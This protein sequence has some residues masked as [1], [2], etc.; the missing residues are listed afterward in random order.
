[1]ERQSKLA[2]LRLVTK[3]CPVSN[4]SY[5]RT[6]SPA[7]RSR[8]EE[9]GWLASDHTLSLG[10]ADDNSS[11][12][13]PDHDAHYHVTGAELWDSFWQAGHSKEAII[14]WK[15]RQG[16]LREQ[17]ASNYH[18]A[19]CSSR[20]PEQQQANDKR[21]YDP[22]L[23]H[24]CVGKSYHL[25]QEEPTSQH[26]QTYKH[27]L[28]STTPTTKHAPSPS[29]SLFPRAVADCARHAIPP[30]AASLLRPATPSAPLPEEIPM[31]PLR[32]HASRPSFASTCT[33]ASATSTVAASVAS[34][35]PTSPLSS[36]PVS[37]ADDCGSFASR[38]PR[39]S[40]TPP[41][42]STPAEHALEPSPLPH[43]P[44]QEQQEYQPFPLKFSLRRPSLGNL[45]KVSSITALGKSAAV[46]PVPQAHKQSRRGRLM[47]P[48]RRTQFPGEESLPLQFPSPPSSSTAEPISAPSLG[49][50]SSALP[51]TPS[52][53]DNALK[54]RD[55][56]PASSV[57][58]PDSETDAPRLVSVFEFDSDSDSDSGSRT[59]RARSRR[60]H[61]H[62]P[63]FHGRGS[64]ESTEQYHSSS[65][66]ASSASSSFSSLTSS[67]NTTVASD[68]LA[69]RIVRGFRHRSG[70][71]STVDKDQTS[72][73]GREL[74]H[75]RSA[76]WE[77]RE[78]AAPANAVPLSREDEK[79][80]FGTWSI[81]GPDD[82]S[83]GA[84]MEIERPKL[85]RQRSE[86]FGRMLGR[87]SR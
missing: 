36:T 2:D 26:Q 7:C 80:A 78:A 44:L 41:F 32:R 11:T 12:K 61:R 48:H 4:Y 28:P 64:S 75:V 15:S 31:V 86:V 1:M 56:G 9:N 52:Q 23:I 63:L 6:D 34:T 79:E 45:R 59:A 76:S 74:R 68:S 87:K 85:R 58:G 57:T 14:S 30:R 51:P 38:F 67:S 16:L 22:R 54:N 18:Q 13:L 73:A 5:P 49:A 39:A 82:T 27:T 33:T 25:P 55:Q 47:E 24:P 37:P 19:Y 8:E 17:S 29:Y 40:L 72:T 77:H 65:S 71:K 21:Q 42:P 66:S 10:Q 46:P 81:G 50:F 62:R 53:P 69:R 3:Y 83:D 60:R 35:A 20:A 70:T 84:K 43:E